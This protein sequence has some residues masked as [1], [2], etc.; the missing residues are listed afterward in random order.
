MTRKSGFDF[1]KIEENALLNFQYSLVDAMT[2]RGMTRADL[3]KALGVSRSRISQLLIS[4]ANPTIKLVA[5]ALAIVSRSIRYVPLVEEGE[6]ARVESGEGTR[7]GNL[8]S[9]ARAVD[10][11][12]AVEQP[13]RDA[14]NKNETSR[15][16]QAA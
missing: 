15:Y 4:E 12:W 3:A 9:A 10:Q 16:A 2:D 14:A 11:E 7:W 6:N 13:T 1:L 5:R 8:V